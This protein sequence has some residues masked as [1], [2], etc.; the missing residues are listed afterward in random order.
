M[1]IT[2]KTTLLIG[3]IAVVAVVV[4]I[5][6]SGIMLAPSFKQIETKAAQKDIVRVKDAYNRELAFLSTQ[7]A[8]WS[9]WDDSY[10]FVSNRNLAYVKANLA[11]ES[12]V[13]LGIDYMFFLD[14]Q[15]K[16]VYAKGYNRETQVPIEDFTGWEDHFVSG[17]VSADLEDQKVKNGL[18]SVNGSL[19]MFAS[20][21]ILPSSGEGSPRGSLV[22]AKSFSDAE[23]KSIGDLTHIDISFHTIDPKT[24][25]KK[26]S[27]LIENLTKNNTDTSIEELHD[28]TLTGNILFKDVYDLPV[29]LIHL[30]LE[31]EIFHQGFMISNYFIF[32]TIIGAALFII[33]SK[34]LLQKIVLEKISIFNKKINEIAQ[35]KDL[36]L[37]IDISGKDEVSQMATN[38]NAMIQTFEEA[39]NKLISEQGKSQAYLKIIGVMIV[40]LDNQGRVTM[41]NKKATEV[42]EVTSEEEIVGKDWFEIFIPENVRVKVKDV[43]S[44]IILGQTEAVE[45]FENEILTARGNVKIIAWHNALIKDQ[46]GTSIGMVASGEDITL[47]KQSEETK[48]KQFEELQRLNELVIGR[49]VKMVELKKENDELRK[50]LNEN[51]GGELSK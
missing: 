30:N 25:D 48:K 31:R 47:T 10:Q 8:D 18:V 7:L 45:F 38:I 11:D 5:I 4:N 27:L 39:S 3:T 24:L 41:V 21:P 12:L 32:M 22:F 29:L 50:Q 26:E 46:T 23:I 1:S 44:K 36:K 14:T 6:F 19:K 33:A 9:T 43:F 37:R 28:K 15:R 40:A 42:L 17:G 2:K 16:I 34:I 13:N 49:E 35:T 51:K 20:L